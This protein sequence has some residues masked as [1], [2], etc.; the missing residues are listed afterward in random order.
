MLAYYKGLF[1]YDAWATGLIIDTLEQHEIGEVELEPMKR[2][3]S[4]LVRAQ[5]VWYGRIQATDEAHTAIWKVDTLETSRLMNQRMLG[6]WKQLLASCTGETL[7]KVV[8][9]QN[10][11]G[12]AFQ[13]PLWQILT[14]VVNHGTHHR[15]QIS[16]AIRA[17]G[18]TPP[19]TDFIQYVR[20]YQDEIDGLNGD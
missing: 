14:H 8:H 6:R 20:Q 15:A 16:A 7:K 19:M 2:W 17:A 13:T 4:H 1:R 10:S 18:H 5:Q 3:V 11:K 12:V 9:Y